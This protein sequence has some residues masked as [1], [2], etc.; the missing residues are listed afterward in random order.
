MGWGEGLRSEF[1]LSGIDEFV[2]TPTHFNQEGLEK[3]KEVYVTI[4]LI[5]MVEEMYVMQK[6]TEELYQNQI[7]KLKRRF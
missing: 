6:I 7:E 5:K 4:K 2:T 3:Y 1:L